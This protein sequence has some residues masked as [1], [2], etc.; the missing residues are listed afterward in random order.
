MATITT[1][2]SVGDVVYHAGTTTERKQHP[3]PD[4]NGTR[5]WNAASPAGADYTFACPRCSASYRSFDDVSLDYTAFTPLVSKRTIGSVRFNSADGGAEYMCHE[6]GV[7]SGQI[8]REAFL[9]ET[10]EEAQ[11][12]AEATAALNN[13]DTT[14]IAKRYAWTLSIS[15]Y[16]LNGALLEAAKREQSRARSMLGSL[17]DLFED[18]E[19]ATDKE[20]IL[21]LVAD[22]KR[23]D[24]HNDLDASAVGEAETPTHQL[25]TPREPGA[26]NSSRSDK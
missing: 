5:K 21:E 8:Y 12:V 9:F 4:C 10:E 25:N 1:K 2:Y 16:Q 14:W 24:W 22:Y 17:T 19:Q 15:D 13:R 20:E 26:G 3:C 6:T 18:I 7:G 23:R 11:R